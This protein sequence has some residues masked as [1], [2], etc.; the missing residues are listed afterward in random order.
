M[1]DQ[2]PGNKL[3]MPEGIS[4]IGPYADMTEAY[5]K[6]V[7]AI[8]TILTAMTEVMVEIADAL[9]VLSLYLEKKGLA[10]GTLHNDDLDGNDEAN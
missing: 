8:P 7:V 5:V 9:G 10:E 3:V 6:S 4:P 1:M 2:K